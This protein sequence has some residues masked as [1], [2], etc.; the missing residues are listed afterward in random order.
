MKKRCIAV[1]MCIIL[2]AMMLSSCNAKDQHEDKNESE[3]EKELR[4]GIT[5]DTFVL[6]RWTRDRDVFVSTAEKLG[7]SV[8][9]QNANGDVEKQKEQIQKFI[10]DDMDVI[11]IVAVDCFEIT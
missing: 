11:V 4:I 10:E 3:E 8:D 5:F 9:V 2:T 6:E 7:A 1:L